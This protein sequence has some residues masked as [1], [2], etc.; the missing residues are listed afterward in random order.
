[1]NCLIIASYRTQIQQT[2][3]ACYRLT[4]SN[5]FDHI[6]FRVLILHGR[7]KDKI[8]SRLLQIIISKN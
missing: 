2:K 7:G 8:N 5:G 3:N 6:V 4:F 1:M